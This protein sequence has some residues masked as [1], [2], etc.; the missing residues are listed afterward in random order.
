MAARIMAVTGMTKGAIGPFTM[1]MEILSLSQ[2]L[3]VLIGKYTI[4]HEWFICTTPAEHP[5]FY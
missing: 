2:K 3:I 4:K 5:R 1:H